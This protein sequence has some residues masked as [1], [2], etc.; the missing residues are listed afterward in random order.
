[1]ANATCSIDGCGKPV[2]RKAHGWCVMHYRRWQRNGHPLAVRQ[3]VGDTSARLLSHIQVGAPDECW[4]WTACVDERGY[5]K[6]RGPET[7][8]HRAVFVTFVGPIPDGLTID[9]ICHQHD[10]C[11]GGDDCPHR[12]CCNWVAH[13]KPA[14]VGSNVLRG[15]APSA[16]NARLLMCAKG[17]HPFDAANT[18]VSRKG[19][20]R[21]RTC[22]NEWRQARRAAGLAA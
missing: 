9:H 8:A 17:L 16:L 6:T 3:I 10:E 5:G 2:F 13:L 22:R 21:C 20:R 11:P 12:R 15:N 4:P 7:L 1:M 14:P 19:K 18:Y